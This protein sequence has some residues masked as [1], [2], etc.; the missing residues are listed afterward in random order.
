MDNKWNTFDVP[1]PPEA[2]MIALRGQSFPAILKRGRGK[3]RVKNWYGP[4]IHMP[5]GE[6]ELKRHW[7][8]WYPLPEVEHE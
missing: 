4:N 5:L 6:H 8:H 1:I 3:D 7:R 2:K